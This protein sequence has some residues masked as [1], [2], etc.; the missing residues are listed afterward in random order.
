MLR[1]LIVFFVF[2]FV[3]LYVILSPCPVSACGHEGIYLGLG[4][5]QL[6]MYTPE[7][8]MPPNGTRRVS[9]GPGYGLNFLVGYDFPNTRWGIQFPFEYA[10]MKLNKAEWINY[11]GSSVEAVL[12]LVEWNNG[13]DFHLVGGA[14]W[15]FLSEGRFYD[16]S[17]SF[18]VTVGVGPGFSYYFSRTEKVSASVTF[19][20]P[21]RYVHYFGDRLSR[22]GTS[23]V[24][25]PVRISMQVGF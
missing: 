24:Q 15:S 10:R 17:K 13:F 12:H 9:F 25:F 16:R 5:T 3:S 21:V 20:M 2:S 14:G 22:N 19:E 8:R 23:V 18:G 4:Y 7:K 1:K 6:F 11:F